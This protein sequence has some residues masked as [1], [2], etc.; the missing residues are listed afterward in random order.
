MNLHNIIKRR[1]MLIREI[2]EQNHS[3]PKGE[4]PINLFED[5][6]TMSN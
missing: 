6:L 1:R 5:W 2:I 3:C 4:T